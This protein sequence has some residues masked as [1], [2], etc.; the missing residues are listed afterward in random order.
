MRLP[1]KEAARTFLPST[2]VSEGKWGPN[3]SWRLGISCMIENQSSKANSIRRI[4][5]LCNFHRRK[6]SLVNNPG[7]SGHVARF[8]GHSGA[9]HCR[10]TR[11]TVPR[12]KIFFENQITIE[13]R[14]LLK[15]C[16]RFT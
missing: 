8:Q 15:L 1:S 3:R 7:S 14:I 5:M 4:K 16:K 11:P 2:A 13:K 10:L 9:D 6:I 12:R